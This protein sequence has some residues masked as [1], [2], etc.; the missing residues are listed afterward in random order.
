VDRALRILEDWKIANNC[1]AN[2][3]SLRFIFGD[4]TNY[5]SR[6]TSGPGQRHQNAPIIAESLAH[7]QIQWHP[8]S[9]GRVKCNV[10]A[11]FS[12]QRNN[13]GVVICIRDDEGTFAL[14]K[15][16]LISPLC[17]VSMG[18]ALALYHALEWLSYMSF[19]HVDFCSESKVT[20]D[21]FHQNRVDV[22]KTGHILTACRQLFTIHFTN[23]KDEFSRRQANEVAHTLTGVATLSASPK[24]YYH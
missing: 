8:P 20:V 7:N 12:D 2:T 24:I 18:E 5:D 10:N 19:D 4:N 6:I 16:I 22:T 11:A 14:V 23:S 9:H 21:A 1:S 17:S 3:N 15:V 13:T